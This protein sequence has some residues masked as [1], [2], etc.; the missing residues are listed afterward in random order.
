[1]WKQMNLNSYLIL[2]PEV[3]LM[4]HRPKHKAEIIKLLAENMEENI[5]DFG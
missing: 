5:V 1:M 2:Y 3:F 4:D